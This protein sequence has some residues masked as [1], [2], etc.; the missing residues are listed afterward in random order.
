[1]DSAIGISGDA[2]GVAQAGF[3]FGPDNEAPSALDLSG[4]IGSSDRAIL[5]GLSR[6]TTGLQIELTARC[7]LGLD[8]GDRMR[9]MVSAGLFAAVEFPDGRA[10]TEGR[11]T[12]RKRKPPADRPV[13]THWDGGGGRE[14]SSIQGLTP[15]LP[16][17]ELVL[18]VADSASAWMRRGTPWTPKRFE[19]RP[20]RFRSG[21][22]A[23]QI[24]RIQPFSR[25]RWTYRQGAGSH[26][27]FR[28]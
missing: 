18:V 13:L 9:S 17:R 26:G 3:R 20:R 27:H 16:P 23:G 2:H 7:R 21:G 25:R 14:W 4:V 1:M 6:Y 22:R 11:R 10:A 28:R 12:K 24:G 19:L 8:P 15:A 5:V